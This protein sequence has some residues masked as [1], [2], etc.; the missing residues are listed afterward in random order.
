MDLR[1]RG[2]TVMISRRVLPLMTSLS[3]Y[4]HRFDVPIEEKAIPAG[5]NGE[6]GL[7]KGVEIRAYDG[8]SY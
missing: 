6:R 7:H 5:Y 8:G 1:L 4:A 3:S 2:G